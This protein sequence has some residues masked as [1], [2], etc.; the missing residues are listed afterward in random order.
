MIAALFDRLRQ[1]DRN[2]LARLVS[3]AARGEHLGE[4]QAALLPSPSGRGAGG[5]GNCARVVAFTGSGGVGKSTLIG[6][7]IPLVREQN[8]KVAVLACDPQSPL[9]GGALLGDRFRMGNSTDDGVFIRSLAAVSGHGGLAEHLDVIIRLL[10]TFGFDVIF[11]ETVGS[12]QGD[13]DVRKYSDVVALLVQPESGDDVQWEKAGI[14]ECADVVIVHKSDLPG[15][16]QTAAQVRAALDLSMAHAAPVLRVST[17]ANTGH[18][19]LWQTIQVLPARRQQPTAA[20]LLFQAALDS[21]G[22]RFDAVERT[23]D[24]ELEHLA[25]AWRRG[26]SSTPDAINSLLRIL[27]QRI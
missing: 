8:L 6:K 9:T 11:L 22:Q 20:R 7:L 24:A 25:D 21:L 23:R 10:E 18:A 1:G 5:E 27:T 13:V 16:D 14:L 15:A 2:A 3:Q 26:E 4:M 19:E 12:G 17:K